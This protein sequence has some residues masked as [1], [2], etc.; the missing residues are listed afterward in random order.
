VSSVPAWS[1]GDPTPAPTR[2]GVGPDGA[3]RPAPRRVSGW[4]AR[5]ILLA[6]LV[7]LAVAA[8]FGLL[9]RFAAALFILFVGV[10]LGM[11]VKP[12]V[13]W[14]RRRG[15]P[16]WIGA[17]A[18]YT[19]LAGIF[20]GVV[21]VAL[22]VI[23]EQVGALIAR[24]PQRVAALRSELLGSQSRTLQRI[25]AYFPLASPPSHSPA[26]GGHAAAPPG[27]DVGTLAR[28]AAAVGR[29]V[30]TVTAVLL[31][32]FYWTLEGDRRVRVLAFFVPFE[33]RRGV[34]EFIT[35]VERTVGAYL[36]GQAV[37]CL[38]IGLLAFGIYSLLGVPHAVVLG[39]IYAIGEAVPVVGP[40]VGTSVAALVAASVSTSLIPP[41]IA[42]A[43]ILQLVEN[44]LLI[45][46]VMGRAVG[47]NPF[48]TLLAIAAFG[49]VLGV[50]GAVLA[51]PLAAIVQLLL[52][53]FL[54]D[55]EAQQRELPVGRDHVSV[56]RYEVRELTIDVRKLLRLRQS[57]GAR[58]PG[59]ERAER[60]EDAVEGI[61]YD[62]DR[63]LAERET[64]R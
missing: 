10:A 24:G 32:G 51:I 61:A 20:T 1:S 39:L 54:L 14:L 38:V 30:F 60:I 18:I 49:S 53:R 35:E 40:I 2:S 41:V 29:N 44:Y 23:A 63:I 34:R 42:G 7:V 22:P 17:L 25:A 5:R 64:P 33:S 55:I 36:R 45:P 62:L 50:A 26:H 13:D 43:V 6:N 52:Y 11:A 37:V 48:V 31:L 57:S 47:V 21:V 28:Y 3:G 59:G 27:L 9:Y 15:V 56:V 19:A 8:G 16:R 58:R 12:G 4:D 46:K